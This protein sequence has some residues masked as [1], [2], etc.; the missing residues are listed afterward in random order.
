MV[1]TL[2]VDDARA[3]YEAIRLAGAGGLDDP[4]E[5]DVRDAAGG[6]ACAR[7]WRPRRG[8]T[9]SPREYATDFAITF[10]LGRRRSPP[11]WPTGCAPRDATVELALRLLAAMPDTLIARKRGLAAAERVSAAAARVLAAGG[12]RSAAG[13][14]ALAGFDASLREDGNALNPGTTADLVT[15]ALFV[16]QLEGTL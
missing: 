11:R 5:H 16:A 12:V 14:S 9:R 4:V 13:R 3:A 8:A 15:A 6:H 7:R 10:E 1:A 2:D